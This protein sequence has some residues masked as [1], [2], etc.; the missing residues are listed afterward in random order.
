MPAFF[1]SQ[2]FRIAGLRPRLLEHIKV[3]RH[4]YGRQSWY[5]LHDR[6][7]GRVHRVTPA[8]FLFAVRM[9]GQR[10]VGELWQELVHEMDADAPGQEAVLN[11]LVQLHGADLLA[12]DIPPDAA[13]LLTRRD[14]QSRATLTRN[15]RSPLSLQIPLIDPDALLDRLLPFVRPLLGW[16][17]LLLWL[18]LVV[19]GGVTAAQHWAELTDNVVD[20][21]LASEGLIALVL[22]YPVM[23]VLHELGHGLMAKRFG[24]EVREMG[25]MLLVLFPIPYVDASNSA[26]LPSKW[27][28]AAV[29]AAGIVVELGLAAGAALVWAA[30]EPG[31]LRAVAFNIMLIGGV[32]TVLVNGNPLLR[33][34]GY[35]V[36]ADIIAVPN[37]A[38]RGM[39]YLGY[40]VN[41]YVFGVH[42]LPRFPASGYERAA[43]LLYTPVS[44]V[45][46]MVMLTSVALFV[47]TN[48]FAAGM[49]M[50]AVTAVMGVLWP[51]LKALSR[52]AGGSFYT[53]RRARA[54]G[55]TFG[56]IALVV[57]A[58]LVLPVPVH[59]NAQ[60]VVWLPEDA[61]VRAGADGFVLRVETAQGA[62]VQPGSLLFTMQHPIA[63]ARMH[64]TAARVE[65]LAAKAKAEWVTDRLAAGVTGFELAQ[66]EAALVRERIRMGLL[67]V[68]SDATGTFTPA[69]PETD[70]PGR[71]VKTGDVLGWVTPDTGVVAR[72]LVPQA[73]VGLVQDR[74]RRVSLRL[75]DQVTDMSTTMLRA[76]PA[77]ADD[78][79]NPALASVNGGTIATDLRDSK[80]LRAF[81]RYFQFDIALPVGS[82][83]A[84]F[85]SRVFV[86]FDFAWEGL[87]QVLYRRA[88]QALLSRFEA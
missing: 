6:L 61:M 7:S 82:V 36:L 74:L 24:C 14:R 70:A 26:A 60:G 66:Q 53:G 41:R 71:Y 76:V 55:L 72:V 13:G 58:L 18:A 30:A 10:T 35:Y 84:P 54:A 1:I 20:R 78:L 65:E 51:L 79:P 33:F 29:A 5:A 3:E 40:V 12:G 16:V 67:I 62:R 21:V 80:R 32:S 48:Y 2:W 63:E 25:I 57:T 38:L 87:G 56:G 85:G 59:T 23:K 37:L 31:M 45:Y 11:L 52:V 47:A 81:E 22:C 83:A 8:A 73:D 68:R 9:D 42:G 77:A 19:A 34:D 46:R 28:R 17:G 50:A 44:W 49:A 75:S 69:Q 88:R 86:R 4:R 43:M 64:V 39:R 27:Q 15:L